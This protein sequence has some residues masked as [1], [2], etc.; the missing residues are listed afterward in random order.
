MGT[1]TLGK[2]SQASKESNEML[3]WTTRVTAYLANTVDL[4]GGSRGANGNGMPSGP[5]VFSGCATILGGYAE[6]SIQGLGIPALKISR[7]APLASTGI[8]NALT[9]L[10]TVPKNSTAFEWAQLN[11]MNSQADVGENVSMYAQAYKH[12][13]AECWAGVFEAQDFTGNTASAIVGVEVDILF[14]GV[15]PGTLIAGI[16]NGIEIV[17]GDSA[18]P[19]NPSGPV[20]SIGSG[21]TIQPRANIARFHALQ[22]LFV[23]G[24]Y[25]RAILDLSNVHATPKAIE[26]GGGSA[27]GFESGTAAGPVQTWYPGV[28]VPTYQGAIR[29]QVDGTDVWIPA[30]SNHP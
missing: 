30:T 11:R 9:V 15:D 18:D 25:T 29:V 12:G 21:I 20:T 7:M 13:L 17:Y 23:R 28:Y 3:D 27:L 5:Q 4:N 24:C 22:A 1:R 10:T 2:M 16:K 6:D 26:M 8:N 19:S 14:N